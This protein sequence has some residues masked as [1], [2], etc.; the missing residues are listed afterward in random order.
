LANGRNDMS[1]QNSCADLVRGYTAAEIQYGKLLL[2]GEDPFQYMINMQSKLQKGLHEK[3]GWNPIPEELETCGEIVDWIQQNND[4]IDDERRELL[5]AMGGMSNG[6]K[7]ATAVWKPWKANHHDM[8]DKLLTDLSD[9][10]Q[11]EIAFEMVDQMHFI[12]SQLLAL[13]L[14][15]KKL[16][17]L[18]YLKNA[19]NIKR[20]ETGY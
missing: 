2:K 20:Y 1:E 15:A 3:L 10:D 6:E 5:T 4:S 18:Y 11:L 7:Q 16:F 8:R 14:D 9:S 13:K 12:Y 19:E 17:C